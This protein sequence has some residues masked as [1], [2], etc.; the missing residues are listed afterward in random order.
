MHESLAQRIVARFHLGGLARDELPEVV[1]AT[2]C[3][4]PAAAC[5]GSQPGAIEALHQATQGLPRK[6]NRAS[7]STAS[8]MGTAPMRA[9]PAMV[10]GMI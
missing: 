8:A 7:A 9:M 2:T 5:C 10:G 1:G 3:T 4:W 6:L